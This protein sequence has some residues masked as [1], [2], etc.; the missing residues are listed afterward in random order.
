MNRLISPLTFCAHGFKQAALLIAVL[1]PLATLQAQSTYDAVPY[2]FTTLAGTAG[3]NG[4]IDATGS[5][6]RFFRPYGL[7]VDAVGSV[8][9]ADTY[10]STIRKITSDGVVTTFAGTAGSPGST[11]ATGS[12]ARFDLP[13][14]VALD[15][16]GNVYVA[17]TYNSTIRKITPAGVTTTFAGLAGSPGSADGTGSAARFN[18]PIG[19]ASDTSDNIY[20]ADTVNDTIRKITSAGVVSTLAGT[21]GSA[22][23]TDATGSAARF[24]QPYGVAVDGAG[25]VYV[26]DT[27]NSTI[28][29]ITSAGVVSTL[30]GTASSTGSLDAT[31]SA[32]RFNNPFSVAVDGSGNVYV[33]DTTNSTVRKITTEGVVTT[34][35]GSAG[36]IGSTDAAGSAARF[37]YLGGIAVNGSGV[38][39]VADSFNYIIRR[40]EVVAATIT[41][42]PG[43][44]NAHPGASAQFISA[45]SGSPTPTLQ[46]QRR[47]FGSGT[48][49]DLSNAGSY[50]NVT[51]GTLT[52]G[53]AT[54][55]MTGDQFRCVATNSNSSAI[56]NVATLIVSFFNAPPAVTDFNGDGSPDI[57]LENAVS[58]Q[59][60]LWLMGGPNNAYVLQGIGL[61]SLDPAWHIVGTADFN[62]DGKPD[63]LLENTSTGQRVLWLMGG[64][65]NAYV[66]QGLDL[67]VLDPTWHIVGTADFNGDGKP[68]ILLENTSSGERVLWLMG[69]PNNAYVLQG[70]GLGS[71]DPAWHIAGIAD[72]NGDGSPDI[73]LENTSTGQRVLWLMG[74]PNNAYVTQG[75]DMGILDPVWH[76]ASIADFNR[77]GSPDIVLENLSTGQRV[78][79]L[80]GGP[81]NAYVILGLDL[82]SLD[83]AWHFAK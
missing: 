12:A 57:L 23:S 17:D 44:Q 3:S 36:F 1:A 62:G 51:T 73:L 74:G 48:W 25:N 16:N 59:R 52:V 7:A 40:G 78:L 43:N 72:F 20:V 63:I 76:I 53:S 2:A 79:W 80:M 64:P 71:I 32:A 21:A 68:D 82:G 13:G 6:A 47:P 70:I 77:D 19:L 18:N 41:S 8:Y 67:G 26:A 75:L 15:S 29:K 58:G 35:A 61:G 56:S 49:A 55:G 27:N 38:L 50:S 14:G 34:L 66:T 30:A 69:G 54:T 60:V 9:V 81:N 65:N 28:R 22:G 83:S 37:N 11:D 46:W 5:A 4:S 42:Q 33:A 39:Y 10:N 24:Y 31:G 45:A